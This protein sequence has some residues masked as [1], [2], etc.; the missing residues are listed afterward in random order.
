[1]INKNFHINYI[2]DKNITCNITHLPSKKEY[3]LIID[4]PDILTNIE[5]IV[6]DYLISITEKNR[7]DII[8][9]LL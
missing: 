2:W 1:M 7:E 3:Q 9:K 4:N 5:D 6:N 8:N